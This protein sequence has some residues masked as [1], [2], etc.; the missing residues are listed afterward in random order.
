MQAIMAHYCT[1]QALF[2]DQGQSPGNYLIKV[3]EPRG[4][5][6]PRAKQ[7]MPPPLPQQRSLQTPLC[8]KLIVKMVTVLRLTKAL[9][10]FAFINVNFPIPFH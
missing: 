1:R 7:I 3:H 8:H 4:P 9:D 2:P 5:T 10:L 6:A